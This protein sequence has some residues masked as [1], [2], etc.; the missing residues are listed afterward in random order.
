[1]EMERLLVQELVHAQ[2]MDVNGHSDILVIDDDVAHSRK[3]SKS[4]NNK[5]T[6]QRFCFFNFFLCKLVCS[7]LQN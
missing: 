3:S 1:M 5:P 6:K 4:L 2:L 7:V